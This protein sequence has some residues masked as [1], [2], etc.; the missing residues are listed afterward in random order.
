V[1]VARLICTF[2]ANHKGPYRA[3]IQL[4][5]DLT[6][7]APGCAVQLVVT[8][9]STGAEVARSEGPY[10][11]NRLVLFSHLTSELYHEDEFTVHA[12]VWLNSASLT[13]LL[14]SADIDVP[15]I[16]ILD[17]HRPFVTWEAHWAHFRNAGTSWQWWHRFSQPKIHRTATT[18]RCAAVRRAATRPHPPSLPSGLEYRDDLGFEWSEIHAHRAELCDHCFFDEPTS[19]VVSPREDWFT[20]RF[21]WPRNAVD[22][23]PPDATDHLV[24]L[25]PPN[26]LAWTVQPGRSATLGEPRRQT[27]LDLAELLRA[28]AIIAGDV[29]DWRALARGQAI[30][31]ERNGGSPAPSGGWESCSFTFDDGVSA[32]TVNWDERAGAARD[33][34]IL[35]NGSIRGADYIRAFGLVATS[36]AAQIGEQEVISFLLFNLDELNINSLDFYS[37]VVSA[38]SPGPGAEATP[39]IDAIAFLVGQG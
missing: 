27:C 5:P 14:F 9:G 17:R 15:V 34:H 19:T 21:M 25:G 36:P 24:A 33:R 39:D 22:A 16:D 35:A 31:F 18:A 10:A 1:D 20:N 7:V 12:R 2:D 23:T 13:G 38:F 28:S 30:A 11:T 37:V 4:R 32:L 29:P 26:G 6:F 8:R 3:E